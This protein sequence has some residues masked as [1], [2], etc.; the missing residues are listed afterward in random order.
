MENVRHNGR[1]REKS[2]IHEGIHGAWEIRVS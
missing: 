2:I 1:E